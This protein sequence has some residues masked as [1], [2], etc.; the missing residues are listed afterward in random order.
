MIIPSSQL[1]WYVVR[2]ETG[3]ALCVSP[4]SCGFFG[5]PSKRAPVVCGRAARCLRLSER[6]PH[7]HALGRQAQ[8][9]PSI[10]FLLPHL[11]SC[12]SQGRVE[13]ETWLPPDEDIREG[14][15][16]CRLTLLQ[17]LCLPTTFLFSLAMHATGMFD[18]SFPSPMNFAAAAQYSR[19]GRWARSP[20]RD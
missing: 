18:P 7:M 12:S 9:S 4:R 2:L 16:T 8:L 13:R 20:V 10:V 3:C 15:P 17:A 14:A 11:P 6:S 5:I 19:S 1:S